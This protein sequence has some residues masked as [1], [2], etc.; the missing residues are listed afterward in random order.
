MIGVLQQISAEQVAAVRVDPGLAGQLLFGEAED[1]LP[2]LDL[3]KAWQG[4]HFLLAGEEHLVL[5]GVGEGWRGRHRDHVLFP[6]L[7][8]MNVR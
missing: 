7:R 3:D 5:E 8:A 2:G 4:I 6:A 1:A